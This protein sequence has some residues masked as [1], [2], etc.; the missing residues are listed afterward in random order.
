MQ[1]ADFHKR[2]PCRMSFQL[3]LCEFSAFFNVFPA[4]L[5]CR[6]RM[7]SIT[8]CKQEAST[9]F[10]FCSKCLCHLLCDLTLDS[11]ATDMTATLHEVCIVKLTKAI[12]DS[13]HTLDYAMLYSQYICSIFLWLILAELTILFVH[14]I[15]YKQHN[16]WQ[17]NRSMLP[18]FHSRRYTSDYSSLGGSD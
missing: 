8:Y 3:L 12:S 9:A 1:I 18:D 15:V 11:I 2:I 17:L 5:R 4:G 14:R 13:I 10:L 6:K 7:I 16:M